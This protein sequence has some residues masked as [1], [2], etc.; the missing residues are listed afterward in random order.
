MEECSFALKIDDHYL[1]KI[2][3]STRLLVDAVATPH[4]IR[5]GKK[6]KNY[7]QTFQPENYN[8]G[9]ADRTKTSVVALK[10]GDAEVCLLDANGN[11]VVVTLKKA[12]LIPSYLQEIFSEKV[13]TTKGAAVILKEN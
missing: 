5:D 12:L 6:F 9:L 13:T 4:I 1:K 3:V 8:I 2:T 11:H 10:R 7:D